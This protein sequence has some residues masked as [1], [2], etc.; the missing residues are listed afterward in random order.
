MS[1]PVISE[2]EAVFSRVA[3]Y[4]GVLSEPLRLKI[5]NTVCRGEKTVGEIVE[6]VG[7]SQANVSK[8]LQILTQAGVI[9][10][11]KEG[12]SVIYSMADKSVFDLCRTV[13]NRIASNLKG[14]AALHQG[15]AE[16][17]DEDSWMI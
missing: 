3:S 11:R 6:I 1:D 10:R 13:C 7:S 16:L 2:S 14:H 12:T 5:I 17:A 8:H 9:D 4:F 15:L